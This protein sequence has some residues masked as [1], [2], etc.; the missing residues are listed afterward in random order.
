MAVMRKSTEMPKKV[1]I[2]SKK[3]EPMNIYELSTYVMGYIDMIFDVDDFRHVTLEKINVGSLM[4]TIYF[5]WSTT[6]NMLVHS[7]VT[8]GNTL[9]TW[10]YMMRTLA[11]YLTDVTV[12][13]RDILRL[14]FKDK[15]I[16]VIAFDEECKEIIYHLDDGSTEVTS[17]EHAFTE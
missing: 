16:K 9:H 4:T 8:I 14:A 6:E 11:T 10:E 5:N 7:N 15:F 12:V 3:D 13:P 17:F 2:S 1:V